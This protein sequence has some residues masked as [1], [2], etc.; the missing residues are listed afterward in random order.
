M[1]LRGGQLELY[2]C[3]AQYHNLFAGHGP[4][5]GTSKEENCGAWRTRFA[6]AVRAWIIHITRMMHDGRVHQNLTNRQR[7][8]V[9]ARSMARSAGWLQLQGTRRRQTAADR[10]FEET[11][12]GC[13]RPTFISI[14]NLMSLIH[15]SAATRPAV[16]HREGNS[17]GE[18][19]VD[20]GP[21]RNPIP[22]WASSF[23][24]R[25]RHGPHTVVGLTRAQYLNMSRA[26]EG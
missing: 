7:Q 11:L 12:E 3:A 26:S 20:N 17:T 13:G 15:E 8:L 18:T 6:R 23:V 16:D 25:Q 1:L 14:S 2:D 5:V 24:G 4:L 22:D 9:Q 19:P 10:G 21:L